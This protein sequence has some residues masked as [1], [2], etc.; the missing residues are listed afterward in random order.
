MFWEASESGFWAWISTQAKRLT[1][2]LRTRSIREISFIP[3]LKPV[4]SPIHSWDIMKSLVQYL[5]IIADCIILP[6][7]ATSLFFEVTDSNSSP[8]PV[9][10]CT[11][12]KSQL[13]VITQQKCT[14]FIQYIYLLLLHQQLVIYHIIRTLLN[15]M[16]HVIK[17]MMNKFG[18][19]F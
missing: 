8:T 5:L 3:H 11:Q 13:S 12:M 7:S 17:R 6:W 10:L 16:P 19:Q 4:F 2:K 15:Y 1:R 14:F 18:M 9:T